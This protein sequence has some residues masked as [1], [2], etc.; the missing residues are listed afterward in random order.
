MRS[1]VEGEIGAAGDVD[2]G[3][4][5]SDLFNVIDVSGEAF[6]EDG[7]DESVAAPSSCGNL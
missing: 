7:A 6:V 4:V 3:D 1:A 2:I 5:D